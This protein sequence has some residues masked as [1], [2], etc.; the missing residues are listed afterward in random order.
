MNPL[1]GNPMPD[2]LQTD[3]VMVQGIDYDEDDYYEEGTSPEDSSDAED[4]DSVR[5]AK[6]KKAK[7]YVMI[8][9]LSVVF[10]G[11]ILMGFMLM[12]GKD[13][14][15]TSGFLGGNK[16]ESTEETVPATTT[17]TW[18]GETMT[19]PIDEYGQPIYPEF[20]YTADELANLRRVGYTAD[21]I[22]SFQAQQLEP[23]PLITQAEMDK[24]AW[25]QQFVAPYFDT[26]SEEWH[27]V[28]DTTWYGLNKVESYDT[29]YT[30]YQNISYTLN[31]DYDKVPAYGHQLFI[32]IH[33]NETS[34]AF[35]TV[36]PQRYAELA[37][38]GNIV[39]V[40]TYT[41]TGDGQS[42]ITSMVESRVD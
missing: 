36:T 40:I 17:I 22:E 26:A 42:F 7:I 15:N 1:K 28:I 5:E 19:V 21:E 33:L 29:D 9:V 23:Q 18:R 11:I 8:G 32:K 38:S 16:N 35:M 39:V 31:A 41:K 3:D 34:Y 13:R 4:D 10:I 2:E 37:Q 25:A 6:Q 24:E 20:K 12:S 30:M 14:G 27:S